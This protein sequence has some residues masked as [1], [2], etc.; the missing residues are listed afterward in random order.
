MP[1]NYEAAKNSLARCVRID[2]CK[3]WADKAVALASYARQ[4]KDDELLKNVKRIRV[5]AQVR[6]GELLSEYDAPHGGWGVKGQHKKFKKRPRMSP[7]YQ[8]GFDAGLGRKD[9]NRSVSMFRVPE[10][11]RERLIENDPPVSPSQLA[12]LGRIRRFKTGRGKSIAYKELASAYG[13]VTLGSFCSWIA[14]HPP[15][16]WAAQ[17]TAD[18]ECKNIREKIVEAQEWLDELDQRLGRDTKP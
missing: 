10:A 9:I 14:K 5:R 16:Y 8:A 17:I 4:V 11:D 13:G 6:M 7:R 18:D 2:E 1:L 3:D 15:A 12:D